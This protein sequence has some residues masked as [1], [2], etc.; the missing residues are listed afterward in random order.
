MQR[1]K[2]RIYPYRVEVP[3]CIRKGTYKYYLKPEVTL[4]VWEALIEK[5]GKEK[6]LSDFSIRQIDLPRLLLRYV[7]K[8]STITVIEKLDL[9]EEERLCICN[10]IGYKES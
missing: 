9:T 8:D 5:F 3:N 1:S 2:S 6:V 7:E 10:M 4:Q